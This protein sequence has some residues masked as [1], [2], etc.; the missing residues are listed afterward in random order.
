MLLTETFT[1]LQ[2]FGLVVAVSASVFAWRA[3]A[4]KKRLLQALKTNPTIA[5]VGQKSTNKNVLIQSLGF[6]QR[7]R[8]FYGLYT[9]EDGRIQLIDLDLDGLDIKKLTEINLKKV[10]YV[11]DTSKS[12]LPIETQIKDFENLSSAVKVECIPVVVKSSE[13][14][15]EKIKFLEEK[16]GRLKAVDLHKELEDIKLLQEMLKEGLV[17]ASAS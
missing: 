2:S 12:S 3:Y 7:S 11:F 5:V 8:I 13:A 16:F 4:A 17:T 15:G 10:L 9:S 14:E 1:V 6:V